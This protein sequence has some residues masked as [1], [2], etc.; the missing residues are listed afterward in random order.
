[1]LLNLRHVH[2]DALT[3]LPEDV[4]APENWP[5]KRRTAAR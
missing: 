3:Q 5:K 1:V 4:R 2:G